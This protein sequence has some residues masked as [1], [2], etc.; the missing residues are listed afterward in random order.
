ME[1]DQILV[2]HWKVRESELEQNVE[3]DQSE[4]TTATSRRRT[5]RSKVHK[6]VRTTSSRNE[7]SCLINTKKRFIWIKYPINTSVRV[8]LK[9]RKRETST[10]F[11]AQ[12]VNCN[13]G[14]NLTTRCIGQQ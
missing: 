12:R 11:T 5:T 1:V 2:Q 8:Q 3:L 10:N 9:N 4:R 6:E 14:S 7:F 13:H